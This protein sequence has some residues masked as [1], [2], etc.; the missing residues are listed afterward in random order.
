MILLFPSV[1]I[2]SGI[3]SEQ[4]GYFDSMKNKEIDMLDIKSLFQEKWLMR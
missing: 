2:K 1:E 3:R 4:I